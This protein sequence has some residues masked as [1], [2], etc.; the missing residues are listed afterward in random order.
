MADNIHP[1][2]ESGISTPGTRYARASSNDMKIKI[3][4]FKDVKEINLAE[5]GFSL[6]QP[7]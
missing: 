1:P 6:W 5:S 3:L 7:E 4:I 2:F